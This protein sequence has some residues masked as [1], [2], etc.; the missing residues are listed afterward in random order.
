MI[1]IDRN[2]AYYNDYYFCISWIPWTLIKQK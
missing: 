1:L 2:M